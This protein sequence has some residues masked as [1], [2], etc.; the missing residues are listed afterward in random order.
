[1]PFQTEYAPPALLLEHK[2]VK[3]Y[4]TYRR[5]D[6]DVPSSTTFTTNPAFTDWKEGAGF[7]VGDLPGFDFAEGARRKTDA[8][9]RSRLNDPSSTAA[10][11]VMDNAM[12]EYAA[13]LIRNAIDNDALP[14][15]D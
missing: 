3:V 6:A 13:E 14:E 1:M 15:H 12:Q 5:D 4:Y 8:L 10:I 7:N 9:K 2:G 11:E